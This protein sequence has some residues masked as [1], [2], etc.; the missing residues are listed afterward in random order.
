VGQLHA[1]EA[2]N[3]L[4]P[5]ISICVLDAVLFPSVSDLHLD[6]RLRNSRHQ[7]VLTD[8]IQ[9][10]FL[11]LP[12][13]NRDRQ[14]VA[15]AGPL[16]KWAYFFR[17]ASQLTPVE[18][19]GRLVDA[20]FSEAAGV[21]EMIAQS[22][23]EREMYEARLKFERDQ[24]WRINAAKNEGRAEG[25]AEGIDEGIAKGRAEGIDEGVAKGR[26]EGIDEGIAE[27]RAEGIERGELS[28][29][30]RVLQGLLGLPESPLSELAELKLEQLSSL[31]AQ[32]QAEI[33]DRR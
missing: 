3:E 28:G 30:I 8:D 32:L 18:I 25:R 6:F 12:K 13:Y 2:Y 24:A 7:L 29:R 22:P 20:E 23:K 11:E 21:L 4:R 10:H 14:P 5:A 1:G 16:E 33:G 15:A 26:A 27:G 17:Y 9:I 31:A 19:G